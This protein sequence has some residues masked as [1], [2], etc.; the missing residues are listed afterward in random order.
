M[1][2]LARSVRQK[3]LDTWTV[4]NVT[5]SR[6][7]RRTTDRPS[8]GGG[9]R[10]PGRLPAVNRQPKLSSGSVLMIPRTHD[11]LHNHDH[12]NH[13]NDDDDDDASM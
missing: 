2:A 4:W 9:R 8:S 7:R 1:S 3:L 6:F 5:D 11:D 10:A 12:D 13:N